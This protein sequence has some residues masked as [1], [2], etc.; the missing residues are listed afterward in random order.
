MIPFY[1]SLVS[2]A[3]PHFNR[4]TLTENESLFFKSS[5]SLS[6]LMNTIICLW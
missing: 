1:P 4:P 6:M 5:G 2:A 3:N